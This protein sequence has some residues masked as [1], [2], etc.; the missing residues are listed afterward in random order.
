[1]RCGTIVALLNNIWTVNN[2]RTADGGDISETM[3]VNSSLES[4]NSKRLYDEKLNML[5]WKLSH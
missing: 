5:T 3:L 1:M 2:Q 4:L